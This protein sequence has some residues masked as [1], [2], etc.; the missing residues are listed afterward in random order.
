M[1]TRLTCLIF[2][3]TKTPMESPQIPD[4]MTILQNDYSQDINRCIESVNAASEQVLSSQEL[5]IERIDSL[6]QKI[7]DIS[8]IGVGF[9][10]VLSSITL[11]LI[12]ALFAFAF[13][14]LFDAINN[15][16]SKYK[17]KEVSDIFSSSTQYKQFIIASRICI[18]SIIILGIV[19][20]VLDGECRATYLMVFNWI[21]AILGLYYSITIL[22]FVT[23][24][25][26]FNK[27]DTLLQIVKSKRE[28]EKDR[29]T[30]VS[31]K[32][33]YRHLMQIIR[34]KDKGKLRKMLSIGKSMESN[35]YNY[36]VNLLYIKRLIALSKYAID[37]D[38]Y[39]FYVSIIDE[40]N[41]FSNQEECQKWDYNNR[42]EP[43]I[44]DENRKHYTRTF[45]IN[46][47]EYQSANSCGFKYEEEL[48]KK[49][50][51]N[52]DTSRYPSAHNT[53]D[54]M[55][56]IVRNIRNNNL[57]LIS[58]YLD[59][60][61]WR[62]NF[63]RELPNLM[64]IK[65]GNLEEIEETKKKVLEVWDELKGIHY[66]M[67]TNLFS[68]GY[69]SLLK[70]FLRDS[71]ANCNSL[72]PNLAADALRSY[73]RYNDKI[74]TDGGYSHWTYDK[75]S[76]QRIDKAMMARYTVALLLIAPVGNKNIPISISK[77][78]LQFILS[79]KQKLAEY[80][81][82][83]VGNV[84]L[85]TLFPEI[86]S[87]D[88]DDKFAQCVEQLRC[89]RK[90][91]LAAVVKD[92]DAHK[93]KCWVE[94]IVKYL[95]GEKT[96]SEIPIVLDYNIGFTDEYKLQAEQIYTNVI[97]N[98]NS[99]DGISVFMKANKRNTC[100]KPFNKFSFFMHPSTHPLTDYYISSCVSSVCKDR[101][102]FMILTA[103]SEMIAHVEEVTTPDFNDYLKKATKDTPDDFVAIGVDSH[104]STIGA[105]QFGYNYLFQLDNY[106][107]PY[108]GIS[109]I[110]KTDVYQRFKNSLILIKKDALP[111]IAKIKIAREQ[112]LKLIN[113]SQEED[114]II[115]AEAT[116][117]LGYS[118][119]YN[120]GNQIT[121]I[122]T[123]P[124]V[125]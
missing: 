65:G 36:S 120:K 77:K 86:A 68:M 83:L 79:E 117:D 19:T 64:Y 8:A 23:Y 56:T 10:D 66:A 4:S 40:I 30:R 103:L 111:N 62:Y 33:R 118:L 63:V 11:P 17:S 22:R 18:V 121:I 47:I 51:M 88:F 101:L 78:D 1:N 25:I 16:N 106:E 2:I 49:W 91:N 110:E 46:I 114:G 112:Q 122:K 113:R 12:I 5:E 59:C 73:A 72:Y 55:G 82:E 108:S 116:I 115:A 92:T 75:F 124:I 71:K 50:F 48:I 105:K 123:K 15:I 104:F 96:K 44:W 21:S 32:T 81:D 98:I 38:D 53:V 35:F 107:I 28:G 90:I 69:Y 94:S 95:L 24:C 7:D 13:P 20:L 97:Q 87:A 45:Y 102:N 6:I 42:T 61:L 60:S 74:Q 14:F 85:R 57:S 100:E 84:A 89:Y 26:K 27:A 29:L 99:V 80:V 37:N 70:I 52:M 41:A 67:M 119:M 9:D 76:G 34:S 109:L 39:Q 43:F 31:L 125:C 93:R 54:I 3:K 58:T